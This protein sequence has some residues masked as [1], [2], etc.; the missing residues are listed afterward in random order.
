M[1]RC[2]LKPSILLPRSL[3]DALVE[4]R[5]LRQPRETGGFLYLVTK[6]GTTG[7]GGDARPII[8]SYRLG[9]SFTGHTSLLG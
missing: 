3:F 9:S 4:Q 5:T 1:R 7:E 6:A 2:F 8:S